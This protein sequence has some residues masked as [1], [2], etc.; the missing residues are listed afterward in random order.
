MESGVL[1]RAARSVP[2]ERIQD[3]S[4][5]QSLVPRMLGLVSVKF[6]TGAG[7]ADDLALQY[8][9]QSEGER[10]R[11]VIKARR[12]GAADPLPADPDAPE[13]A[14]ETAPQILFAMSEKRLL[15]FGLFEFSLAIFAVSVRRGSITTTL[16][17]RC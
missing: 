16:P 2:F 8:L 4:L 15:T 9:T 10:L 7:G 12:E 11:E 1:S 6:E 17:P 3:I 13:Q 14:A 5:E